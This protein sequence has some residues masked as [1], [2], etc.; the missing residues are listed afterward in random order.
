MPR[1]E[2]LKNFKIERR[3]LF[4][5]KPE[6][7]KG[8]LIFLPY[9]SSEDCVKAIINSPN[10]VRL[11]YWKYIYKDFRYKFKIYNKSIFYNNLKER[12]ETYEYYKTQ[13]LSH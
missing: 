4:L 5:P 2:E 6:E 1:L 10:L 8:N 13:S 9:E 7:G 12:N 3:K 11:T